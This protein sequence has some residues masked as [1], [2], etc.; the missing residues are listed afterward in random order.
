MK[1]SIHSL[2]QLDICLCLQTS[3]SSGTE[4]HWSASTCSTRLIPI[5]TPA[6]RTRKSVT[7]ANWGLNLLRSVIRKFG[8]YHSTDRTVNLK[9]YTSDPEPNGKEKTRLGE[10]SLILARREQFKLLNFTPV[11]CIK[12]LSTYDAIGQS[13]CSLVQKTAGKLSTLREDCVGKRNLI[14]DGFN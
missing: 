14:D 3:L 10:M 4:L 7:P 6:S 2:C 1:V 8:S 5:P 11:L 12:E 9:D 13:A